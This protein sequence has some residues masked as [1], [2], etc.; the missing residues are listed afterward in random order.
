MD[1]AADTVPK[2]AV[3]IDEKGERSAS[4]PKPYLAEPARN[5]VELHLVSQTA[6]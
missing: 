6:L 1:G 2:A 4:P 3:R 5:E